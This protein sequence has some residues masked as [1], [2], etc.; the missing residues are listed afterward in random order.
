[1]K[2]AIIFIIVTMIFASLFTMY[3]CE[4]KN[5]GGSSD[6][7]NK[8]DN[9]ENDKPEETH[10]N[11]VPASFTPYELNSIFTNLPSMSGKTYEQVRD[12]Y[13]DGVEGILDSEHESETESWYI[14]YGKGWN[15]NY[16]AQ[17]QLVVKFNTDMTG[18]TKTIIGT[19]PDM[20]YPI[21]H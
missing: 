4:S 7:G 21:P 13:F 16:D 3:S 9:K 10:E 5:D 18:S 15:E 19:N 17:Y 8:S 6:G 2:K 14:W 11:E 20:L 12:E 1:M